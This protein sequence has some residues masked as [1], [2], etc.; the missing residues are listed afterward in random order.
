VKNFKHATNTLLR[1]KRENE[2]VANFI[3]EVACFHGSAES[4]R[5]TRGTTCRGWTLHTLL[6]CPLNRIFQYNHKLQ[7]L[8]KTTPAFHDDYNNLVTAFSQSTELMMQFIEESIEQSENQA[9][10]FDVKEGRID[11][12]DHNIGTEPFA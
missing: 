5:R 8:Y 6:T 7:T 10:L 9:H 2:K 4:V 1:Y 12:T 3:R 11:V